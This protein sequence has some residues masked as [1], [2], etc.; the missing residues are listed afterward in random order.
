MERED[1][2]CSH[3]IS[4]IGVRWRKERRELSKSE[5]GLAGVSELSEPVKHEA[6]REAAIIT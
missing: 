1:V 5:L 4:R 2:L 3:K 6:N